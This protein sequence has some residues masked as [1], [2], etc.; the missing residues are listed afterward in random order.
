MNTSSLC[1]CVCVRVSAH[2]CLFFYFINSDIPNFHNKIVHL[3]LH[4]IISCMLTHDFFKNYIFIH[5]SWLKM[6]N[7]AEQLVSFFF[8]FFFFGYQCRKSLFSFFIPIISWW[9]YQCNF[10]EGLLKNYP[11]VNYLKFKLYEVKLKSFIGWKIY[12]VTSSLELMTFL[13][14]GSKLCIPGGRSM[15]TTR[16]TMLKNKPH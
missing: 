9:S 13:P 5:T 3:F 2:T 4:Y 11:Q 1:I 8:F 10:T 14:M 12:A 6:P 15:G 7:F 16:E